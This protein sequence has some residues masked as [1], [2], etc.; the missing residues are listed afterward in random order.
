V[1]PEHANAAEPSQTPV[2]EDEDR[3]AVPE[4]GPAVV[5]GA[6]TISPKPQQP[7]EG[8]GA[9]MGPAG[10]PDGVKTDDAAR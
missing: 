4:G 1:S 5:P 2:D 7:S 8:A 6:G 3:P 9:D 10:G